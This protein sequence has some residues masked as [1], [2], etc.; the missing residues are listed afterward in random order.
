MGTFVKKNQRYGASFPKVGGGGR[1]KPSPQP[2]PLHGPCIVPIWHFSLLSG[3]EQLWVNQRYPCPYKSSVQLSS[4]SVGTCWRVG[5][6][7]NT[8]L[9]EPRRGFSFWSW[10]IHVLSASSLSWQPVM[11]TASTAPDTSNTKPSKTSGSLHR[12]LCM[13]RQVWGCHGL[14]CCGT[15]GVSWG[16]LRVL[17]LRAFLSNV[18]LPSSKSTFSHLNYITEVVRIGSIQW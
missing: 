8:T 1:L 16:G 7:L 3:S 15:G 12:K 2:L 13:G 18:C 5:W 14:Q 17:R 9:T 10:A 4:R 11:H 6:R